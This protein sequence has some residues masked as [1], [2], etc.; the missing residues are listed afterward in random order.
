MRLLIE[1][2]T[3]ALHYPQERPIEGT[4]VK[5]W[6]ELG[7]FLGE[8]IAIYTRACGIAILVNGTK[9]DSNRVVHWRLMQAALQQGVK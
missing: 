3:Y 4:R 7:E 2:E 8:G 5:A 1:P 9:Y 6:N